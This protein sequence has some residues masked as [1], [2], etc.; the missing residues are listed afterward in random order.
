MIFSGLFKKKPVE[1]KVGDKAPDFELPSSDVTPIR[2]SQ[3]LGKKI[4]VLYFY[5]KDHTYF[6]IAESSSFR[7]HYV[8]FQ[9]AGAEVVGVSSDTPFSH[10]GFVA[11]YKL[12]FILLSDAENKVRKLYGVPP[13]LGFIPGRTTFVIDKT[14]IIRHVF[15]SQFRYDSHVKMALD[16][17]KNLANPSV[18]EPVH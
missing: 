17:V 12:P 7:D 16:V 1:L 13:T 9:E 18:V 15:T 2:L 11:K 14:G 4:I 8:E 5:P 6:C 3:F 10:T